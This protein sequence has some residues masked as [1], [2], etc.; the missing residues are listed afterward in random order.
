MLIRWPEQID[1][2]LFARACSI[3]SFDTWADRVSRVRVTKGYKRL[4]QRELPKFD[5][6]W[7]PFFFL[8]PPQPVIPAAVMIPDLQHE[9]FPEFFDRKT[10]CKRYHKIRQTV[11]HAQRVLT[12]SEYSK[13]HLMESYHL[14]ESQVVVT[15]LDAGADFRLPAD[16]RRVEEVRRKYHLPGQFGFFPANAWPHKNHRTLFRALARYRDQWG[17]PPRIVLAGV[18]DLGASNLAQEIEACGLQ[19][20]VVHLGF[21]DKAD[22][23]YL[24]DAASFLVFVTLFEGF[25]IPVLEAMRRG[26]PV[27][28]SNTTSIP[29][30]AADCAELVDPEDE[31][32]IAAAIHKLLAHPQE[33]QR[34][35]AQGRNRAEQFSYDI[36]AEQ[37]LRAFE[38]MAAEGMG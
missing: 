15:P 8:D 19:D 23:P 31:K 2:T 4:F 7:C 25:G 20:T 10:L 13:R 9:R 26:T 27:I 24:Y 22:M 18:K 1:V 28:A 16:A 21:V 3:D 32:A 38:A 33:A 12:I 17:N 11:C 35:A 14:P 6:L 30:I 34:Y 37:T 29:E 36:A 5:V